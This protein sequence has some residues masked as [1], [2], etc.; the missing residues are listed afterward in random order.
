MKLNTSLNKN[1][2][3]LTIVQ[4]SAYILPL[5]TFPY[6]ARILGTEYFGVFGF[7]Q[8]TMQYF[9]LL[10]EYGFNW[11]ATQKV[12]K[13]R[14][15]KKNL[16]HFFWAV[17][18]SK[19]FLACVACIILSIVIIFIPQFNIL[20]LVILAFSPLIIG[21]VIYPIWLF[22]GMENMKWITISSILARL[23]VIPL[24]FIFV[25]S[26]TDIWIAALLQGSTSFISGLASLYIIYKGR[27]IGKVS[28][29]LNEIKLCLLDG[30]HVFVS[31]SAISLY[32]TS[33]IIILGFISGPIA[34]AY[35]NSANTIRNALQGLFNPI[36]Q[37]IYPRISTLF[38]GQRKEAIDLIRRAALYLGFFGMF[39]SIFLFVFSSPLVIYGI[40]EEYKPAINVLRWMAPIPLFIALSNIFGIQT[41]LNFGFKKQFSRILLSCGVVNILII[42]PLAIKFGASG[43]AMSI[44]ITEFLVMATMYIFLRLKGI[45]LFRPNK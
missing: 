16:S 40:G 38:D 13:L 20:W 18:W 25:K 6:L 32:T 7:C 34:V 23:V 1:I 24:T 4:G 2:I 43:A 31:T 33:T 26:P 37:G 11:T 15:S 35:F 8:A 14:S 42:I 10:T 36:S 29:N 39:L 17:M 21:S 3:Y 19:L 5:L 28:F 27:W 9:V 45:Y 22:Q 30:W 12:A 41:M 44:L